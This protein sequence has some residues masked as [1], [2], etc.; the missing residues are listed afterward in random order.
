MF[1]NSRKIDAG[2]SLIVLVILCPKTEGF[3][4]TKLK[5]K[6]K[7]KVVLFKSSDYKGEKFL[8]T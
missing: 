1:N 2:K 3:S 4:F 7:D 8:Y 5:K 6:K